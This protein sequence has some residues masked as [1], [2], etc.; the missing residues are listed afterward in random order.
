M[1]TPRT[2]II[3][4]KHAKPLNAPLRHLLT[5]PRSPLLHRQVDLRQIPIYIR[6]NVAR[7]SLRYKLIPPSILDSLLRL[8]V[9][10]AAT[11]GATQLHGR[12]ALVYGTP[13]PKWHVDRVLLRGI[14]TIYGVGTAMALA[15]APQFLRED[16]KSCDNSDVQ[17]FHVDTGDAVLMFGAGADREFFEN[18]AVHRSPLREDTDLHPRLVVQTDCWT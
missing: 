6:N 8:A 5:H 9:Q 12:V 10:H 7:T 4:P 3:L 11:T 16:G 15:P 13:C 14:C 18:A 1:T 17:T 2:H